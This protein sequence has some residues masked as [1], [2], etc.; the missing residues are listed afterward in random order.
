MGQNHGRCVQQINAMVVVAILAT[1]FVVV[2]G[3]IALGKK[4]PSETIQ[5]LK[6]L[7]CLIRTPVVKTLWKTPDLERR[8]QQSHLF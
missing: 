2:C 1:C 8:Q 3:S 7:S 4:F 5:A 6:L